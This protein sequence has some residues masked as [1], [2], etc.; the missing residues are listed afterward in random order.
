ML[1]FLIKGE[2]R[3]QLYNF[4]S[5]LNV[6]EWDKSLLE[7]LKS[8]FLNKGSATF[9]K[10]IFNYKDASGKGFPCSI[11][12]SCLLLLSRLSKSTMGIQ[13]PTLELKDYNEVYKLIPLY[14]E[15][16]PKEETEITVIEYS[17]QLAI[18]N[19]SFDSR[20]RGINEL[21]SYIDRINSKESRLF[22]FIT[23]EKLQEILKSSGFL[24][25]IIDPRNF[26][27]EIFKRSVPMLKILS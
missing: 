12:G 23:E 15:F 6:E 25:A 27:S 7:H 2:A 20:L 19:S 3:N 26:N 24:E 17:V 4:S 22:R 1:I 8:C 18:G 21:K 13:L 10:K 11:R 16:F 5:A 14:L 9:I